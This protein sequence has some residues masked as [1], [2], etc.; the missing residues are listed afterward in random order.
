[1]MNV[2]LVVETCFDCCGEVVY[3][4]EFIAFGKQK[5]AVAYV[6]E[7]EARDLSESDI[8]YGFSYDYYIMPLDVV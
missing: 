3:D 4:D 2:W 8:E 1:M 5:D 6:K 7:R